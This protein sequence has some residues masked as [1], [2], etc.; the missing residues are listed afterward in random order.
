LPPLVNNLECKFLKKIKK[1]VYGS[2]AETGFYYWF[3]GVFTLPSAHA[4]QKR[5]P[6]VISSEPQASREI[7]F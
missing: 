5:F 6:N 1:S 4:L 3:F 7:C 2:F